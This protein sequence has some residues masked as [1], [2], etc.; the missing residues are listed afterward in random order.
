[1]DLKEIYIRKDPISRVSSREYANFFGVARPV[2]IISFDVV[3]SGGA[4]R[5]DME[6]AR[7]RD[8]KQE[9]FRWD[10]RVSDEK[11]YGVAAGSGSPM[12]VRS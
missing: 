3:L 5:R 11:R 4:A 9:N 8:S 12:V 6:K 7:G 1:M 2:D 10:S